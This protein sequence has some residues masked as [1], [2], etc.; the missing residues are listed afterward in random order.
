M[1]NNEV[2]EKLFLQGGN[3]L[4]QQALIRVTKKSTAKN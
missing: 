1:V 4:S 3:M 2:G